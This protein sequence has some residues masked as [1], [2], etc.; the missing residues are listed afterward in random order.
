MVL[1]PI[2]ESSMI[3]TEHHYV[4]FFYLIPK[5][6]KKIIYRTSELDNL[7]SIYCVAIS[8]KWKHL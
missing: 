5:F 7:F 4:T 3:Y 6:L 1:F 2:S 8:Y